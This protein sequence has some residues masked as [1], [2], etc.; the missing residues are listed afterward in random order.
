MFGGDFSEHWIDG[1]RCGPLQGATAEKAVPFPSVARRSQFFFAQPALRACVRVR[2]S[3]IEISHRVLRARQPAGRGVMR[4]SCAMEFA[5]RLICGSACGPS[6]RMHPASQG[7]HGPVA[8][9]LFIA[10]RDELLSVRTSTGG[11]VCGRPLYSLPWSSVC[12]W[13]NG[14]APFVPKPGDGPPPDASLPDHVKQRALPALPHSSSDGRQGIPQLRS[15]GAR[16][17]FAC[18]PS[19]WLPFTCSA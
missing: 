15:I 18:S 4:A 17:G 8:P 19:G 3:E 7:G 2:C 9:A 11:S 13:T 6:A 5:A 16:R 14:N 12:T 10:R 1:Q